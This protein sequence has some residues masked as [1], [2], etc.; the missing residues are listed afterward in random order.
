MRRAAIRATLLGLLL[1]LVVSP[2]A[3]A[4]RG[5]I[6]GFSD[7]VLSAPDPQTRADWLQRTVDSNAGLV[8]LTFSWRGL[9]AGK[10]ADATDPADPAY[11]FERIDDAVRDA[12]ERGLDVMLTFTYAPG[13]AEGPN[14]PANIVQGAWRPDPAAF[15]EFAR[16]VGKRYSGNYAPPGAMGPLPRVPYLQPWSEPNLIDHLAPQYEDNGAP[17][18]PDQYRALLNAFYDGVKAVS[19]GTK[20][21][22]AGT[23]PYGDPENISS[24][25]PLRFWRDIFCLRDRKRLKPFKCGSYP[26]LDVFAHNAITNPGGPDEPAGLA[27]NASTADF[28]KIRRVVRAAE[29]AKHVKP[30]GTRPL[31]STEMWWSTH[32]KTGISRKRQA[33]WIQQAL[34]ILWRGGAS[35]ALNLQIRDGDRTR[36][37]D[38][39][40]LLQSGL[41]SHGGH[42]K[43]SLQAFRFPFVVERQGRSRK[44][45]AW[46]KAPQAGKLVIE[47]RAERGGWR[48]LRRIRVNAGDVFQR[49]VPVTGGAYRARVGGQSSVV[50]TQQR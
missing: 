18:S 5:L 49:T 40:D 24:I 11:G 30:G 9:T 25:T 46:G 3:R 32:P 8:M 19:P 26:K 6:T 4:E 29:R 1:F 47:R 39:A 15:G 35:V 28:G 10:P 31:W 33:R 16:A 37:G 43:P 14:R 36:G 45:T 12:T 41:Y 17:S 23:A 27:D 42:P 20:V 2:T 13:Y 48:R 38:T 7:D 34:F 21:V 22:G 50:W 44:S